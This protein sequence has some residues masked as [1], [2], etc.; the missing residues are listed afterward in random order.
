MPS[1]TWCENPNGLSPQPF[2]K[3]IE[4]AN[5]ITEKAGG[6]ISYRQLMGLLHILDL[7]CIKEKGYPLFRG[8]VFIDKPVERSKTSEFEQGLIETTVKEYLES[9]DITE[10]VL[11]ECGLPEK[12]IETILQE[13]DAHEYMDDILQ[14]LHVCK[15]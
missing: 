3:L 7:V 13:L 12:E 5:I 14:G 8:K 6:E 11:R 2:E 15:S 1:S 4:V 10:D 9:A